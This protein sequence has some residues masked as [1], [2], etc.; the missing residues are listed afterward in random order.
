MVKVRFY[1]QARRLTGAQ[2]VAVDDAAGL[3]L[4]ELLVRWDVGTEGSSA[5]LLNSVLVNGR[6]CVFRE[7]L[8]TPLADGDVVDVLPVVGG[9]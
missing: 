7:G 3:S 4:R 6:N 5:G 2:E 9:G 1:G 8:D